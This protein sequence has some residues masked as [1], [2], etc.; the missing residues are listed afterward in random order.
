MA[1]VAFEPNDQKLWARISRE[2]GGYCLELWR[3]GARDWVPSAP[4]VVLA[5]ATLAGS[6]AC[7]AISYYVLER[8]L[9]RYKRQ[10]TARRP[11]TPGTAGAAASA[12]ALAP[13]RGP[14]S[15]R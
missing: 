13:D 7:A 9:M 11:A 6:A 3:R 8:P 15:P 2:L 12:R 5:L 1:G 10:R 14:G 4:F